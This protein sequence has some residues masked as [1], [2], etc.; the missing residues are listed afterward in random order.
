ME[1]LGI[2]VDTRLQLYLLSSE[3]LRKTS[4]FAH[5]LRQDCI[6]RNDNVPSVKFKN[7]WPGNLRESRSYQR[8]TVPAC[9][10]QPCRTHLFRT[11]VCY[12]ELVSLTRA[13][14]G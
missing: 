2:V 5:I 6:R 13:K 4:Q 11:T 7:W 12:T 10:V 14:G 8:S 9:S 3:I 1:L